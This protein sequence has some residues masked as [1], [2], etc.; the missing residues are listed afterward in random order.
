MTI[1]LRSFIHKSTLNIKLA[2]VPTL[3][4]ISPPPK[5][6][7]SR[8]SGLEEQGK[9]ITITIIIILVVLISMHACMYICVSLCKVVA[10]TFHCVRAMTT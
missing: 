2:A 7:I 10:N 5:M 6:L 3:R 8:F 1:A 9:G 4:S